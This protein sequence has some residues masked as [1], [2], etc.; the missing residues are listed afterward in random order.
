MVPML[1]RVE[2]YR[3]RPCS[4]VVER[5][6]D[7]EDEGTQGCLMAADHNRRL[8]VMRPNLQPMQS[9]WQTVR[10]PMPRR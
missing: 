8:D 1:S 3:G 2:D 5:R 4:W 10:R 7:D 9:D 6:G